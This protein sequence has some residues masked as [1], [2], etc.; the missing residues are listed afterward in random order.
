[1]NGDTFSMVVENSSAYVPKNSVH[2]GP[3]AL[4]AKIPAQINFKAEQIATVKFS[5]PVDGTGAPALLPWLHFAIFDVDQNNA[6]KP[7]VLTIDNVSAYSLTPTTTIQVSS[8][9]GSTVF[10]STAIAVPNVGKIKKL[11]QEQAD[12]SIVLLFKDVTSISLSVDT[13]A[14]NSNGGRNLQF[15]GTAQK[16]CSYV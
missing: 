11:T 12:V 15:A 2:N 10:T 13:M 9:A 14:F 1:M 3:A 5:F 8:A 4:S 6:G 7:T 16:I